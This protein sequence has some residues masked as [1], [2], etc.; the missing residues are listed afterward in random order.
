M[1]RKPELEGYYLFV[2]VMFVVIFI[3]A[4]VVRAI[5]S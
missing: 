3:G 2:G 5:I 4:L 1:E